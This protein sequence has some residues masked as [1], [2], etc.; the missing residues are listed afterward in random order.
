MG[1]GCSATENR[2]VHHALASQ[3][4]GLQRSARAAEDSHALDVDLCRGICACLVGSDQIV[5][6]LNQLEFNLAQC[7]LLLNDILNAVF[8]AS[9]GLLNPINSLNAACE[10]AAAFAKLGIE[11]C[12]RR[13]APQLD[14]TQ[15]HFM[16]AAYA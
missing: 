12:G 9:G 2:F 16:N 11:L 15:S 1:R 5:G 6:Q 4:R 14:I 13:L 10:I 3:P 8:Q 7:S